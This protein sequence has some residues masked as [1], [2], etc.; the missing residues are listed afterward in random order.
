SSTPGYFSPTHA[1][2]LQAFAGLAAIALQNALFYDQAQE[3]A[4]L[5]ERQR[6]ARN[7]HDAVSQ[8]LFSA[9]VIAEALPHLWER[10]PE[11]VRPQLAELHKLTRGAL[12]EMRMLLMEL[13]PTALQEAELNELLQQLTDA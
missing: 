12:A 6:L 4:A 2:R 11:R 9:S 1:E 5:E 7:L 10:D 8:M 3:L 13:R